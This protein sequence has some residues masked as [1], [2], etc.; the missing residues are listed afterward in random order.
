MMNKQND[1]IKKSGDILEDAHLKENPYSLP[2]GYFDRMEAGVRDKIRD[3]EGS[4]GPETSGSL[5]VADENRRTAARKLLRP[6]L[7]MAASFLLIFGFA[8]AIFALTGTLGKGKKNPSADNATLEDSIGIGAFDERALRDY[9]DYI[10]DNPEIA[11][12]SITDDDVVSYLENS[13]ITTTM[14]ADLGY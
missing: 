5:P 3:I 7:G 13:N 4:R 6:A 11:D 12:D 10:A 2:E 8:Y 9:A 14:L 1:D